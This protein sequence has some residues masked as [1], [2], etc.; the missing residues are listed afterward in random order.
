MKEL[1]DPVSI[2]STIS[3]HISH[4]KGSYLLLEG[5]KDSKFYTRYFNEDCCK[6]IPCGGKQHILEVAKMNIRTNS[7]IFGI[8]DSDF[9]FIDDKCNNYN[10]IKFF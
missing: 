10:L 7:P 4:H 6:I 9:D 2:R 5:E 1:L 3:F 8:V